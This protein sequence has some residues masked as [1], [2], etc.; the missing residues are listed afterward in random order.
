M[1][2][3]KKERIEGPKKL[4]RKQPNWKAIATKQIFGN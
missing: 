2:K 3:S 4:L 1:H